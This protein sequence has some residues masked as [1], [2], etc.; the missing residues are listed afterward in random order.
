[1]SVSETCRNEWFRQSSEMMGHAVHCM[2]GNKN[3]S[4]FSIVTLRAWTEHAIAQRQMKVFFD[5]FG[6]PIGY[7]TWAWLTDDVAERMMTDKRF[8]LH[9]TEWSEGNNLWIMDFCCLP[10]NA[11]RIVRHIRTTMFSDCGTVNWLRQGRR[12]DGGSNRLWL[13]RTQGTLGRQPLPMPQ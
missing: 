3:Y 12:K 9:A 8:L 1:M 7:L 4:L 5:K 2:L 10:G 11:R 13:D 6:G